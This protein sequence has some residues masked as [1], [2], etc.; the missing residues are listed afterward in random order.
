MDMDPGNSALSPTVSVCIA[1]YNGIGLIDACLRSVRA[2]DF[3]L[4]I[5]IIVHDDASLDNSVE[6]IR[7]HY[8][9][10]RLIESPKNVGFCIANNRMASIARGEFLL[11]LNNDATLFPNAASTLFAEASGLLHEG[12]LTLP[13]YDAETRALIDRGCMLDPF[14]NPIPNL[15]INTR[16]VAMVIGACLWIPK[17]LWQELGGFPEWYES[18][19]EDLHLCCQARLAA[20]PVRVCT[21][22]GYHHLVG[23]SFG[24]GRVDRGRLSTASDRRRL[25][26]RNKTYAMLVMQPALLL[27]L[28]F[29]IH[30]L[31]I[32]FEGLL[33]SLLKKDFR[34]WR[35]IYAPLIPALWSHRKILISERRR[36]QA[37]KNISLTSWLGTFR[38]IPWKLRMI[39][40]YG[41]P[42]IR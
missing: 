30:L 18:I 22:S 31:L 14:F 38:W 16:D 32:H 40:R 20:H 6:H 21:Q 35:K 37:H 19:G 36:V 4:P 11:L 23:R 27:I 3:H 42:E 26:E 9:S 41:I 10:V 33:L 7:N 15:D 17:N 34:H 12:I 39:S 28:L 13:Q 2:Q 5:E 8:P 1:N 24:G 25:S 29:P